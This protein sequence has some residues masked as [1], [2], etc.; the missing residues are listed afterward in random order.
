MKRVLHI[1]NYYNPH[2]GGI[3]QTTEDFVNS[4]KGEYEQ[5]IICFKDAKKTEYDNVDGIDV[6][7][8]GCQTKIA[9]QSIALG[10]KKE[11]KKVIKEFKPDLVI[12]HYPNPFVASSLLKYIK[13]YKLKFVL[14]WHLD[15]TKQKLLGK[16]FNGQTKRLLKY[17]DR[18]VSTSNNYIEGSKYL[19]ENKNKTIVIPSCVSNERVTINQNII[20]QSEMLKENFKGKTMVFSFGRH[21]EYKGFRYLIEASK[22]LDDNYRIFVGGSGPLTSELKNMAKDD[23]KIIFLGKLSL[24]NLKAYLNASDIF[25]FPSITKNEAFGLSLAE[26]MGFKKPSVT[27]T[28]KGSGVNYVALNN[29]TS[30]EVENRNAKAFAEAI[31]KL[32][33]DKELYDKLSNNTKKRFDDLFTFDKYKE[34]VNNLLRE[35]LTDEEK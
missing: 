17:A 15:I 9:S 4:I 6:I 8:V 5:K 28:I 22:Y 10:Y 34:N 30:I 31:M 20:E 18:I 14:Y 21:V 7:R 13:K 33:N 2:T 19:S 26:S 12:F 27:F 23:Y 35:L 3:E 29:V 11:L 25:A 24:D 32:S 16:L 1:P